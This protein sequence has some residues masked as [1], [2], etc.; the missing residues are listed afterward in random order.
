M[1]VNPEL[2]EICL[3]CHRN[4]NEVK[5]QGLI[6]TSTSVEREIPFKCPCGTKYIWRPLSNKVYTASGR[7]LPKDERVLQ[8]LKFLSK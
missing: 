5:P 4:I 1:R 6:M 7:K 8:Q 3:T 2:V